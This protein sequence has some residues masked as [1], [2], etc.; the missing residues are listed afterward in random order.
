MLDREIWKVLAISEWGKDI[1]QSRTELS[2]RSL[3]GRGEWTAA[4]PLSALPLLSKGVSA[5]THVAV[6]KRM[7][8]H[9][10]VHACTHSQNMGGI[11]G[12][13]VSSVQSSF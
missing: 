12:M 3:W 9:H 8:S 2:A 7:E 10:C 5:W 13:A 1:H 11:Y 4:W 6:L